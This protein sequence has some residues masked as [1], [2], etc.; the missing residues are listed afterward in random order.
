MPTDAAAITVVMGKTLGGIA[1]V[2]SGVYLVVNNHIYF[3]LLLI[4][5]G[6]WSILDIG[7]K[8]ESGSNE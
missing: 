8:Q 3:A 2:A 4:G 6:A 5:L 1:M 7:Y